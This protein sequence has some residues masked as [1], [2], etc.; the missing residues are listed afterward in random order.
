VQRLAS[1]RDIA[2]NT[3][4]IPHPYEDG[5]A[6]E[7]IKTHPAAFAEGKG[8]HCAIVL[9]VAGELCGAIGLTIGN[10]NDKA[11][12]GYWMGKPY[13]GQGYCTE[14]ARAIVQYG[15]ETIGLHRIYSTHF[16]NNLASGRVMQK[17]GMT[18]EGCLRQHTLKWGNYEDVK[19]Y[20]ILK[21]DWQ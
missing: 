1:D 16:S 18:Y 8:I 20:G 5:V 19:L 14:A 11:A 4:F 6:E 10:D 9:R 12:L 7:W 13:W 3:L 2:A 15:F 21:S 17:I